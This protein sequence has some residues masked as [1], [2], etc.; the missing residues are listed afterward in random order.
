MYMY[1]N[2]YT[3]CMYVWKVILFLQKLLAKQDKWCVT[4]DLPAYT[5]DLGAAN[6]LFFFFFSDLQK[7]S[8][9]KL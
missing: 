2:V 4:G 7:L 5:H 3:V 8:S 6:F 9:F 1:V